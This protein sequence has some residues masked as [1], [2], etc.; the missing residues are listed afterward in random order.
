MD[1]VEQTKERGAQTEQGQHKKP[2]AGR[3]QKLGS[4][5]RRKQFGNGQAGSA[6]ELVQGT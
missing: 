3:L 1:E 2:A 6:A 4:V 5:M